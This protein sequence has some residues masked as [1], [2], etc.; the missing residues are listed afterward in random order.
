M[1][2]EI[3]TWDNQV[4]P[5]LFEGSSAAKETVILLHGIFSSRD[6]SGRFVR[7]SQMHQSHGRRVIRYDARCHG[8]SNAPRASI[9]VSDHVA[10]LMTTS[11][12]TR[13]HSQRVFMVASSYGGGIALL[14]HGV[15]L[16]GLIDRLVLLNPVV[17][18]RSSFVERRRERSCP[19]VGGNSFSA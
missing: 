8:A 13:M 12:W 2:D 18:F 6:E 10:D 19:I 16:A 11:R 4:L 14:A 3:R 5:A 1:S 15:G 17:D 9:R 7:Q